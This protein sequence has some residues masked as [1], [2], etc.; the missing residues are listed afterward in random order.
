MNFK[1]ILLAAAVGLTTLGVM[2][3][4]KAAECSTT[5]TYRICYDF[6]SRSGQY[7]VWDV[8][9]TNRHTTEFMRV[10][11]YGKSVDDWSSRGGA[12]QSEAQT[13]AET[14]CSL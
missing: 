3:E 10:T 5:S 12:S 1:S 6:I 2:P 8:S 11:C 14:F 7:N 4:A 13:L 9:L